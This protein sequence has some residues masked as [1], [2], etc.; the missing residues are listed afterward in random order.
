[1]CRLD[2]S[3]SLLLAFSFA[4]RVVAS[5]RAAEWCRQAGKAN[6]IEQW[7]ANHATNRMLAFPSL[8]RGS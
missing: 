7:T 4:L 6:S 2:P 3:R 1:M 5:A 8:P